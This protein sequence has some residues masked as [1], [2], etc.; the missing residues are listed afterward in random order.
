MEDTGTPFKPSL[1]DVRTALT[2][3]IAFAQ[4]YAEDA[5]PSITPPH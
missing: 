5:V 3:A 1:V 2:A 4:L